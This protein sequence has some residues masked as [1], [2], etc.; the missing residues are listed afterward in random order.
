MT[1]SFASSHAGQTVVIRFRS[2]NDFSLET[3]FFYDTLALDATVCQ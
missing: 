3:S 1:F 2:T